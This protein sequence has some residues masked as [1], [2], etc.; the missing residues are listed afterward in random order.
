MSTHGDS[1]HVATTTPSRFVAIKEEQAQL[2][3]ELL[4]LGPTLQ[5]QAPGR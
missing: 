4:V 3:K 5:A 1:A 2:M